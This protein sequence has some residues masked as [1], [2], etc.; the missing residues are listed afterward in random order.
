MSVGGS[1]RKV[2]RRSASTLRPAYVVEGEKAY[3]RRYVGGGIWVSH[4]EE[5]WCR[6]IEEM[7]RMGAI[8]EI[9]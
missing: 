9:E 1:S 2:Q 8:M 6:Q 3:K 7:L 5:S 4:D